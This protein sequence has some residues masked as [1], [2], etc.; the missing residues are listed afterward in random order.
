MGSA[1]YAGQMAAILEV[2]HAI[3]RLTPSPVATTALQVLSRV[4]LVNVVYFIPSTQAHWI[5][6]WMFACWALIEVVRYPY[7]VFGILN[8]KIP[9]WLT[10]LRFVLFVCLLWFCCNV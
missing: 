2:V 8:I 3:V 9:Y 1:E 5:S 10:W 7:Y 4:I 6:Q